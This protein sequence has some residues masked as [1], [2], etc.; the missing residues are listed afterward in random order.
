MLQPLAV[1]RT[2][3]LVLVSPDPLRLVRPP[4]Q[5]APPFKARQGSHQQE[6]QYVDLLIPSLFYLASTLDAATNTLSTRQVTHR[7]RGLGGGRAGPLWVKFDGLV[8]LAFEWQLLQRVYKRRGSS[9][10]NTRLVCRASFNRADPFFRLSLRLGFHDGALRHVA[11]SIFASDML[12][13]P[14]TARSKARRQ[15]A[16]TRAF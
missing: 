11:S 13:S 12:T 10:F 16:T 15:T 14:P 5:P 8:A 6:N 9:G 4:T 7:R 3:A 2:P 1:N